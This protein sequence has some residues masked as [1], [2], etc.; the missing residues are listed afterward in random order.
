MIRRSTSAGLTLALALSMAPPAALGAAAPQAAP[1]PERYVLENVRLASDADPVQVVLADGLI[2]SVLAA[3][4]EPP[5]G[6]RTV[7][8]GGNLLL[9]AFVDAYSRHGL[10]TPE[11]VVDRDVPVPTESDVRVDMRV[12]NRRGVQPAF[13]AVDGVAFEDKTSAAIREQGFGTLCVAPGGHLLSGTSAVVTTRT[14]AARDTVLRPHAF[15]HAELV[16]S[17]GGYPSTL[18]GCMAQ[19]RQFLMDA[20]RHRVLQERQAAGKPGPRPPFD[21]EL[22]A[23]LPVLDGE[24]LLFCQADSHRDIERWLSLAE[25]F[26]FRLAIT[27]GREAFRVADRL[28]AQDVTVVLTLDWEEEVEDPTAKAK[29]QAEK[30]AKRSGEGGSQAEAPEGEQAGGQEEAGDEQP[31]AEDAEA[32]WTYT[33][34]LEVRA[35]RRRLWEETRDCAIALNEAGVRVVYGSG[36]G[37]SKQ[38]IKRVRELVEAGLPAEAALA[39]L[40]AKGAEVLGLGDRLGAIEP[41]R[42]ASLAIWTA[43]PTDSK[44]KLAWLFVDGYPHEFELKDDAGGE[45]P[46]EGVDATGTWTIEQEEMGQT[47]NST[48]E[49][50]MTEDGEV[51]GTLTRANPMEGGTIEAAVEGRVSG[52][53]LTLKGTLQFGDV[54]ATFTMRGEL[55]GDTLSG[56]S[57]VKGPWGEFEQPFTGTRE[58]DAGALERSGDG[59]GDEDD[60]GHPHDHA[61]QC[62]R[63]HEEAR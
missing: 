47:S 1:R 44:A 62:D 20:G 21:R 38:L 7:D 57:T 2:E 14:A 29:K 4:A 43:D 30:K 58:P 52:S 19:L 46:D 61:H 37:S 24:R 45:A 28:A 8:G 48:A 54:E 40:T 13:R 36:D 26:G 50:E 60:H 55:D 12:A 5:A 39:S 27:G 15:A 9:P 56:T 35:E 34:P 59:D 17:G 23:I 42:S 33:E 51:T 63:I 25:E 49:L 22:E 32:A 11:P 16:P 53:T 3:D 10:E 41:G 6:A 18:M 31:P